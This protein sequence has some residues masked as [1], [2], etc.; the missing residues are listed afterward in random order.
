MKNNMESRIASLKNQTP[1]STTSEYILYNVDT[2]TIKVETCQSVYDL[3]LSLQKINIVKDIHHSHIIQYNDFAFTKDKNEIYKLYASLQQIAYILPDVIKL[4]KL[5]GAYFS[6]QEILEFFL[7][8]TDIL[9]FLHE[10]KIA[11]GN[12]R[13]SSV[14]FDKTDQ[15]YIMDISNDH[16]FERNNQTNVKQAEDM[17]LAPELREKKSAK[18]DELL[19]GDIW[20][21]GVVFMEMA[22]LTFMT[23]TEFEEKNLKARYKSC[24]TRYGDF[25]VILLHQL[26][27]KNPASRWSL[28]DT[29]D[30]ILETYVP[31][32]GKTVKRIKNEKKERNPNEQ[33]DDNPNF[34]P[35]NTTTSILKPSQYGAFVPLK[36]QVG[37]YAQ[38]V[39]NYTPTTD[40]NN[41][42]STAYGSSGKKSPNYTIQNPNASSNIKGSPDH[43]KISNHF[44]NF[45]VDHNDHNE[46]LTP[47]EIFKITQRTSSTPDKNIPTSGLANSLRPTNFKQ[48]TPSNH[49][50]TNKFK[51]PRSPDRLSDD[52]PKSTD[53]YDKED[54]V[55]KTDAKHLNA[56]R[57][58]IEKPFISGATYSPL[59]RDNIINKKL[60]QIY[61]NPHQYDSPK[62]KNSPQNTS[63]N[64]VEPP[65][66]NDTHP[67]FHHSP[68]PNHS[69]HD[70]S[71]NISPS[72]NDGQSTSPD[73]NMDEV[74]ELEKRLHEELARIEQEE[75]LEF[76][77]KNMGTPEFQDVVDKNF[78]H[79]PAIKT[80]QD[81]EAKNV[82]DTSYD[83]N[84]NNLSKSYGYDEDRF[85]PEKPKF[86][87]PDLDSSY[88]RHTTNDDTHG[89]IN[90]SFN[91]RRSY[92]PEKYTKMMIEAKAKNVLQPQF[93]YE[94]RVNTGNSE[95]EYQGV[96][97][98]LEE[99]TSI[100]KDL[101]M[102]NS[103]R[104]DMQQ[105]PQLKN[106]E[107]LQKMSQAYLND[108]V[109]NNNPYKQIVVNRS[110]TP[111]RRTL[112]SREINPVS[113]LRPSYDYGGKS[114]KTQEIKHLIT[115]IEESLDHDGDSSGGF[116]NQSRQSNGQIFK[117]IRDG[118]QSFHHDE[119]D[120]LD[121]FQ[122]NNSNLPREYRGKEGINLADD[123][124]IWDS[125]KRRLV[126]RWGNVD[127]TIWLNCV[128]SWKK[129]V[130]IL[131][132]KDE[133]PV[134]VLQSMVVVVEDLNELRGLAFDFKFAKI[135]IK[136]AVCLKDILGKIGS[137][138]RYFELVNCKFEETESLG[139]FFNG[140]SALSK[141][142]SLSLAFQNSRFDEF[143]LKTLAQSITWMTKLKKISLNFIYAK[144]LGDLYWLKEA[145]SSVTLEY[146]NLIF[147]FSEIE[148]T[149]A[150]IHVKEALTD[151]PMLNEVVFSINQCKLLN[152]H[153]ILPGLLTS[154]IIEKFSFNV[155]GN[156]FTE[157]GFVELLTL[158]KRNSRA[159]KHLSL[160][161]S[162]LLSVNTKTM[163]L[164]KGGLALA[165]ELEKLTLNFLKCTQM[166]DLG[167]HYIS[168]AIGSLRFMKELKIVL[169]GCSNITDAAV[170]SICNAVVN[171][172]LS[173]LVV[174]LGKTGIR[175]SSL[176]YI[177]RAITGI[178]YLNDIQLYFDECKYL[179]DDGFFV[180]F[181]SLGDM[182]E[183]F[184]IF[185]SMD[186]VANVSSKLLF[187]VASKVEFLKNMKL[188]TIQGRGCKFSIESITKLRNSQNDRTGISLLL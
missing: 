113:S 57:Y 184:E 86:K 156:D 81:Y 136:H 28:K 127:P 87:K 119:L 135:T 112:N 107:K 1:F 144:K 83:R 173:K 171:Q 131:E 68:S 23:K 12:F 105:N 39:F 115:Q 186:K 146:I 49:T 84:L 132:I 58:S 14:L 164:L 104:P 178:R 88:I 43:N 151:K 36:G 145:L 96:M 129:Y 54:F 149:D 176:D 25:M 77:R 179:T 42:S 134:E 153:Y 147:D 98:R 89:H 55:Y 37:T 47:A 45:N 187:N 94:D 121:Q 120:A 79:G 185:I 92:Q 41:T 180:L 30:F 139:K 93:V 122:M 182:N 21:L 8:L 60:D 169:H 114:K 17:Y 91:M 52:I 167:V 46:N 157:Q 20:S 3:N 73:V 108:E 34:V 109:K 183:K 16:A 170:D 188:L 106:L 103:M 141:L 101:V 181:D 80:Y 48:S 61:T 27:D 116:S 140:L 29:Q 163:E 124:S 137:K 38:S 97:S 161:F 59:D 65:Y 26:L 5:S 31:C 143:S 123:M 152:A 138:L 158:I 100:V 99:L 154:N 155:T 33:A 15:I 177:S 174:Y 85:P 172:K 66:I 40:K 166:K 2:E 11:H 150:S 62:L 9:L 128:Y 133:I 165:T 125:D 63:K 53:P 118:K 24:G 19:K 76:Q 111:N 72:K 70:L 78:H 4:R 69:Y 74:L 13:S 67:T 90:S 18:L 162:E 6:Q 82:H 160:V 44:D 51:K 22:E 130:E 142:E 75:N 56:E 95:L 159:L 7:A 175:D 117:Q 110:I 168:Q 10:K 64:F 102:Q 71:S 35:A 126:M 148:P 32:T 50:P